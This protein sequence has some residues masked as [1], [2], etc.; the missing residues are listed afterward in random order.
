MND[1]SAWFPKKD[2]SLQH[3]FLPNFDKQQSYSPY[4]CLRND[5]IIECFQF[6]SPIICFDS[7]IIGDQNKLSVITDQNIR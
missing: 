5:T 7:T 4:I 3:W 1:L 6:W 2:K